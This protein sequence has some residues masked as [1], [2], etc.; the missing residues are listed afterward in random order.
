MASWLAHWL[1]L[2]EQHR[3]LYSAAFTDS[4]TGA[5]NRRYFERFLESAIKDAQRRRQSLTILIFDIDD[6]KHYNDTYGHPAGD[7]V[8][9]YTTEYGIILLWAAGILTLY[10]GYDYF[11]AGLK[12]IVDDEE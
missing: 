3:Q 10:T 8:L 5:W 9:P 2:R 4:L 12:H 6:F 7:K 1:A 11:R